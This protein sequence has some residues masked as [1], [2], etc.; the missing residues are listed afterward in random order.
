MVFLSFK[1]E[2]HQFRGVKG[3]ANEFAELR[4]RVQPTTLAQPPKL[5][6]GDKSSKGTFVQQQQGATRLCQL[7]WFY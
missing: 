2:R 3:S 1:V 7:S 5:V 4:K 6:P